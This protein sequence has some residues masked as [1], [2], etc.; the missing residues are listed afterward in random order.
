MVIATILRYNPESGEAYYQRYELQNQGK[1]TIQEIIRSIYTELDQTLAFRDYN[2]FQGV[3]ACC[4]VK[5]NGKNIKSCSTFVNDGDEIT[6]GP[7]NQ[8]KIIKDL[9]TTFQ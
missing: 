5:L 4:M 9:V 6:I 7:I 1:G 8:G 2:C 3:C